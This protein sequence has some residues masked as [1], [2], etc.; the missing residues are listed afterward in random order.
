MDFDLRIIN[1]KRGFTLVELLIVVG[2]IGILATLLMANFIGVRQ[3]ARDAQRKSDIR[4][5]QSALEF[6]RSDLGTYPASLSSC[7]NS[8]TG[9]S[10]VN[11]YMQKLPCD[12]G[13]TSG[14]NSG[15]YYYTSSGGTTYGLG[16]CLENTA[17]TQGTATS[18]GGS[19][20]STNWYYVA[21]N[22]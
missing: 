5:I 16:A 21:N 7:G 6:Y 15:T 3:R 11:T 20:C 8:L 19:G 9:G 2:I 13:G 4:Q 12:P 22:P 14:Y 1:R 17:D 18:P 10:P